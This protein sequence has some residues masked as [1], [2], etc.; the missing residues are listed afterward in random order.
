M[1]VRGDLILLS[2][3]HTFFLVR[4]VPVNHAH[5]SSVD[6]GI[7]AQL[8][9]GHKIIQALDERG[10]S[11][12]YTIGFVIRAKCMVAHVAAGT[13]MCANLEDG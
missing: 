13:N 11:N 5:T 8:A 7:G 9:T 2:G 3:D 6:K 4:N 10:S 1:Q 12:N